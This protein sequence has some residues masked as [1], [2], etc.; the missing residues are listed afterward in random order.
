MHVFQFQLATERDIHLVK[1]NRNRC[2]IM[3]GYKSV[4]E[5]VQNVDELALS[6]ALSQWKNYIRWME[7]LEG[8]VT[9]LRIPARKST[10]RKPK[11]HGEK[12]E[13]RSHF[14]TACK[15]E[16]EM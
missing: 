7:R 5:S 15:I 11:I 8:S 2:E 14:Q 4:K 1:R 9:S 13:Y 10:K 16:V 3:D 6:L 12:S